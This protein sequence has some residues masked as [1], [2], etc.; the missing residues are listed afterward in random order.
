[1]ADRRCTPDDAFALLVS[2]SQQTNTRCTS[3]PTR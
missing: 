2:L 1:M 3:S